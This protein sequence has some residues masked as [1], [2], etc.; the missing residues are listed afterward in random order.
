MQGQIAVVAASVV[1]G[2]VVVASARVD[3]MM[4][5]LPGPTY[6]GMLLLCF[7]A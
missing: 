6:V 3:S 7:E 4:F 5:G 1:V 2:S